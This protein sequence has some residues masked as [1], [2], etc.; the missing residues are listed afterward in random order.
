MSAIDDGGSAFPEAQRLFDSDTQSW[1]VLSK[2]GMSLRDWFAG[3]AL[4]AIP[5]IYH[6]L[7]LT[8]ASAAEL[9]YKIADEMLESRKGGYHD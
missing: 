5:H 1:I 3:Q 8:S 2:G 4:P 6:D 9:A 7:I